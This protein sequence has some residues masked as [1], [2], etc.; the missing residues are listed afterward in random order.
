[1]ETFLF[2]SSSFS[3]PLFKEITESFAVINVMIKE[4]ECP[5]RGNP[6]T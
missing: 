6:S 3:L 1:M 5:S 2:S 4:P